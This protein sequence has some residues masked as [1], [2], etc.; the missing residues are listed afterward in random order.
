MGHHSRIR[1]CQANI[2]WPDQ[3]SC[4]MANSDQLTDGSAFLFPRSQRPLLAKT[5]VMELP[6]ES[7]RFWN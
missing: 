6:L 4:L 2:P 3:R 5:L 1:N 7:F